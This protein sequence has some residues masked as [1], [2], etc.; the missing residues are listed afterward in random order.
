[1]LILTQLSY[2]ISD[3]FSLGAG[4]APFVL[5]DGALPA[6]INPKISIPIKPNRINLGIGGLWGHTFYSSFYQNGDFGAMYAQLT[7][8]PRDQN[9]TA[10]AG[11]IYESGGCAYWAAPGFAGRK[12]V[13]L[14]R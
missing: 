14:D 5:F 7:L 1:M 6:W 13:P 3:R 10:G 9:F 11:Y 12:L 2:G 8:G 4:L